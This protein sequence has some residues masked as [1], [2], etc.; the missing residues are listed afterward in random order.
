MDYRSI[1]GTKFNLRTTNLEQFNLYY[2]EP[3]FGITN[4]P[5]LKNVCGDKS[6]SC[7]RK[8]QTKIKFKITILKKCKL[9]TNSI[10]TFY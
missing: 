6:G 10:H 9:I 5:V 1:D 3:I 8:K 2:N 4:F 7:N